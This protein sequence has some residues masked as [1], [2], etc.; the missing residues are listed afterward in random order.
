MDK[1][2][3][4]DRRIERTRKLLHEA[5]MALIVEKG[6]DAVSIQDIADRADVARTTFYLHFRDKDELLFSG[7]TA[8][9]DDLF[10]RAT[11][12]RAGALSDGDLPALLADSTDYRHVQE[13]AAFYRAILGPHGSPTF[14][15]R[16]RAYLAENFCTRILKD[17]IPPGKQ[18]RLPL[19][20]IAHALAGAQL[21]SL[22]WWLENDMPFPPEAMARMGAE[23]NLLGY[24]RALGHDEPPALALPAAGAASEPA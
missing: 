14:L 10:A 23:L 20:F 13:H 4:V 2:R 11:E 17:L 21:G 19:G 24:W 16:V 6:Y 3:K 18:P 9:Y 8:L 7:L 1:S 12:F 15:V 22:L 5:L